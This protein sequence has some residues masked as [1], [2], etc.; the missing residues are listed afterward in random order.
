MVIV[1][2]F[3]TKETSMIH[4]ISLIVVL[5]L[6]LILVP[7]GAASAGSPSVSS[8]FDL[9]NLPPG[10]AVKVEPLLATLLNRHG[11]GMAMEG[12]MTGG[13]M[14]AHLAQFQQMID[15]LPAGILVEV[16]EIVVELPCM[17][18]KPFHHAVAHGLLD[19][20]PG[21]VLTFV[22]ALGR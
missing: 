16:L 17:D 5:T 12:G 4:R 21:Q 1:T 10:I 7:V 9:S 3:T 22:K 11:M 20:P 15:Q 13:H 8:T 2:K 6:T 14:E 19:Q 18:M